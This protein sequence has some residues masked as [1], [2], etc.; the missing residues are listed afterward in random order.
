VLGVYKHAGDAHSAVCEFNPWDDAALK[1]DWRVV[2]AFDRTHKS[3]AVHVT[4]YALEG[5]AWWKGSVIKYAL[6]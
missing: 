3:G 1:I 2:K 5:S 6:K 4:L